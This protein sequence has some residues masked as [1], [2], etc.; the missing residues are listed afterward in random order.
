MSEHTETPE[1]YASGQPAWHN[2][3]A[4][5][6]AAETPTAVT[7]IA[8]TDVVMVRATREK[9]I[10]ITLLSTTRWGVLFKN[11]ACGFYDASELIRVAASLA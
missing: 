10:A 8:S 4:R 2:M 5:A 3:P 9:G 11:G 1:T 7:P 6:I